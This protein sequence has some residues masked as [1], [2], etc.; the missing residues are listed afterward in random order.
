MSSKFYTSQDAAD[1]KKN[2]SRERIIV[3][4][5]IIGIIANVL[6]A[7]FKAAVGLL[8][9]SIAIVLDAVNNISDAASS[10]I[11]IIGTKLA[12]KQPDRKHPFGYGRIEYL[13]AMII[14]LI[15]LYAGITSSTESVK[16]IINPETP[17][18]APVTL[19]I[20]A[21]GVVV[22]IVLG[23]FVK[24]TGEK[25]NSDSLIAS[26]SD[27]TMDSIISASTLVAAV[28]YLTLHISLEAWL[29]AIISV[30]I[31]KSGVEMLRDTLSEILGERA[32]AELAK[33]VK[34]T[35]LEFPEVRGVYDLIMQDY[36]PDKNTGS[37]HIEVP[38]TFRADEIDLLIRKISGAVFA[39]HKVA[40]TAVSIYSYNTRNEAALK[41]EENVRRI[42]K[43]HEHVLQVHGFYLDMEEKR[44]QFDVM[45]GFD[46]NDR[47]AVFR[48]ILK[49]VQEAYPD[50]QI[51]STLDLD[52][53]ET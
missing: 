16:K 45:I 17:D 43:S 25:V 13:S 36:G 47:A 9:H 40:L 18:Y 1:E 48:E 51:L 42:V 12:G 46:A 39:K 8:S 6:L 32:D 29:G 52:F 2:R 44:M 30:I 24:S 22:K 35:I 11:T 33:G 23:R 3:R 5:S 7:A 21:V 31:I 26:G 41:I 38:D 37:V 50:Y 34:E 20:V 19:I 28:L 15:I 10:I 4:T 49:D 53:T 27:A 14:S